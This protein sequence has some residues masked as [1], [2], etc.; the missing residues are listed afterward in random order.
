[1]EDGIIDL[2]SERGKKFGFTSDL[3]DG[4]L[5]KN[6]NA[7]LISFIISKHEGKG[8]FQM[9]LK[10]IWDKGYKINIPTPMGK[11]GFI[12]KKYNFKRLNNYDNLMG[13]VEVWEK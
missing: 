1:M 2:D 13:P 8:N 4:W 7:I 9:L 3:F 10:S 12:L 11:M 5:W 6:E